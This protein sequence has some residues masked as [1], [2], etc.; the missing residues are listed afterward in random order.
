MKNTT[1]MLIVLV[2][3]VVV[4]SAAGCCCFTGSPTTDSGSAPTKKAPTATP[5]PTVKPTSTPKPTAT[6]KPLAGADLYITWDESKIKSEAQKVDW[7]DFIRNPDTYKDKL[8]MI[9]ADIVLGTDKFIGKGYTYD[10]N[11]N[12]KLMTGG[13]YAPGDNYNAQFINFESQTHYIDGDVLDIYGVYEGDNTP[14]GDYP[15]IV[16]VYIVRYK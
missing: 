3:L 10:C 2:L 5:V 1:K 4:S 11:V 7:E 12:P 8:I 14:L 9:H 13:L 16:P 6:P 15:E